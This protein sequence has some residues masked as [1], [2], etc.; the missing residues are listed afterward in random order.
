MTTWMQTPYYNDIYTHNT[1]NPFHN[2]LQ[3]L[4]GTTQLTLIHDIGYAFS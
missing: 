2:Y 1:F 3:Y 4:T